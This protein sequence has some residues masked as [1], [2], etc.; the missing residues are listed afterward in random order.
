MTQMETWGADLFK[1]CNPG[2]PISQQNYTPALS[3]FESTGE[4]GQWTATQTYVWSDSSVSSSD[5]TGVAGYAG[6]QNER[7]LR[8]LAP[9]PVKYEDF[10]LAV[11]IS[12]SYTEIFGGEV[13]AGVYVNTD[14]EIGTFTSW[15]VNAGWNVGAGVQASYSATEAFTGASTTAS[16]GYRFL[17]ASTSFDEYGRLTGGSIGVGFSTTSIPSVSL[18]TTDV[19]PWANPVFAAA[20]YFDAM[21][22][23][24]IYE[25]SRR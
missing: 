9:K 23:R 5:F 8:G 17:S 16:A 11:G 12:A 2:D 19:S 18:T 14:Y 15:G 20:E 13:A 25:A 10:T 22:M 1:R 21:K 6:S 7:E 3:N 24:L 4:S